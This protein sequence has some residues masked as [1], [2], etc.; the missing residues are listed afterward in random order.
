MIKVIDSTKLQADYQTNGVQ[1]GHLQ[2]CN[3][4]KKA[5]GITGAFFFLQWYKLN[6]L[7]HP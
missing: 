1:K 2:G 7:F 3:A 5:P 4:T 6:F